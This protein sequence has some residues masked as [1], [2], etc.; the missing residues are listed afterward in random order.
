M[1]SKHVTKTIKSRTQC[2]HCDEVTDGEKFTAEEA[3]YAI[4]HLE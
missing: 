1:P 3:Q 2:K 4:D